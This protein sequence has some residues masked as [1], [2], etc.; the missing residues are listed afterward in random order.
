MDCG[1]KHIMLVLVKDAYK[2][3]DQSFNDSRA[4]PTKSL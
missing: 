2:V 3:I 1:G 4:H